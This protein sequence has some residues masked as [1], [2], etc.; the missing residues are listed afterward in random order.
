MILD[1]HKVEVT[2]RTQRMPS[3]IKLYV[4]LNRAR[5][6][7]VDKKA[8]MI[9]PGQLSL[10]LQTTKMVELGRRLCTHQGFLT[11]ERTQINL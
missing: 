7:L 4:T 8:S 11:S 6:L 5:M 3:T 10:Q 1:R 9:N 2:P